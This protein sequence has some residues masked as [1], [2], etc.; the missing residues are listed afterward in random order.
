MALHL[1]IEAYGGQQNQYQPRIGWQYILTVLC[2][3]LAFIYDMTL[4]MT[5]QEG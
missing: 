2:F 5:D 3:V 1:G 4:T